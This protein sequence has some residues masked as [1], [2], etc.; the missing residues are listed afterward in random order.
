MKKILITLDSPEIEA[1]EK[2]GDK[3]AV[4]KVVSCFL[5]YAVYT[6]FYVLGEMVIVVFFLFVL[7]V[8]RLHF[9]VLKSS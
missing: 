3:G 8:N 1:L 6:T 7:C 4:A 2:Q 9:R 5:V